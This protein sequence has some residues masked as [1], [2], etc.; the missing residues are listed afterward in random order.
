MIKGS[1][2][3]NYEAVSYVSLYCTSPLCICIYRPDWDKCADN[4]RGGMTRWK[5][6]SEG[7]ASNELVDVLLTEMAS[8]EVVDTGGAEYFDGQVNTLSIIILRD[9]KMRT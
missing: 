8:G 5:E 4:I 7:K 1:N 9:I 6:L 2:S 3:K